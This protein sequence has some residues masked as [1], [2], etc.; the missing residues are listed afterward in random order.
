MY[1]VSVKGAVSTQPDPGS[2]VRFIEHHDMGIH[3]DT[4][5]GPGITSAWWTLTKPAS[6]IGHGPSNLFGGIMANPPGPGNPGLVPL[7]QEQQQQ[8]PRL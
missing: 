6:S 5:L 1:P 4:Q 8:G 3:R 2:T 7:S